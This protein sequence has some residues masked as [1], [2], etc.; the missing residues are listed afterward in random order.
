MS[1]EEFDIK[2]QLYLEVYGYRMFSKALKQ[3]IQPILDALNQS[4]SV[5]FTN[6]IA[7]MLYTEVP[8]ADAMKTFYNTA[9]NKQSRGYVKWLKANLPS[10]ATIGVGFENPIMDAALKEYFNTIGGKHIKDISDTTLKKVQS[11]FQ[12]AL[13][14]NEGFRGAER[15]LIKEVGMSKTRARMIARTESVMVTNAAK[16]TQS[17][18]MPILME[19]TWIHDHPKN[20]RNKHVQLD[21]T[22]I[23]LDKKF[24]A[25]NGIMMKH[26]GDPAGLEINN[27]NCKCT[28]LTKAKLD[29]ENNI[30]Y[31]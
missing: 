13:E 25:I 21:G 9:W 27:I 11:A 7:G 17:D 31:K 28:M 1:Q 5:A 19:K 2:L 29:K 30:I 4:E 24:K 8:I 12:T 10:Q 26:P 20:P 3:S 23:D 15:R 22:T 18:I 16:Y 14:N 6:S